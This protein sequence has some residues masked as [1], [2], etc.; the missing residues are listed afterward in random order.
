MR[1]GFRGAQ[2]RAGGAAAMGVRGG[3]YNNAAA[4]RAR[5]CRGVRSMKRLVGLLI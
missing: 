1:R 5:R 4:Q 3:A 2:A